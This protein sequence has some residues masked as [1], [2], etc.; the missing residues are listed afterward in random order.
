MHSTS[1]CH[2]VDCSEFTCD[3]YGILVFD[4]FLAIMFEVDIAVGCVLAHLCKNVVSDMPL[5]IMAVT[6]I[7]SVEAMLLQ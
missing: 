6:Y 3:I 1:S 7:C 5:S 4:I 2:S